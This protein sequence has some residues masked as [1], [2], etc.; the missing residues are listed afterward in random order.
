MEET[1]LG[2]AGGRTYW[3]ERKRQSAGGA[4]LGHRFHFIASLLENTQTIE[5]SQ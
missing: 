1:C 4:S 5:I 2:S 3:V